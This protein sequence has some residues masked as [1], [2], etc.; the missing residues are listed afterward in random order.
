[1][2]MILKKAASIVGLYDPTPKDILIETCDL[3][4]KK[5]WTKEAGARDKDGNLIGVTSSK[6]ASFCI[7]GA[8]TR[9][10]NNFGGYSR[11]QRTKLRTEFK[12][13]KITEYPVIFWNDHKAKNKQ[14]VLDVLQK[15]IDQL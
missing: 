13:Q 2:S 14:E 5:G 8:L 7:V 1:M 10:A 9:A 11:V 4:D 15:T 6:A 12:I 3:L